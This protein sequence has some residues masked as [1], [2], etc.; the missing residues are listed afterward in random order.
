MNEINSFIFGNFDSAKYDIIMTEPTPVVFAER[1]VESIIVAG[2]SGNIIKDNGRYKNVS[3]P[4]RCALIPRDDLTLREAA[5]G[6]VQ[7]L[8]M[9]TGY[10]QLEDTYDPDHF[11]VA[12]VSAGLNI[13]SIV[14]QAGK[15]TLTFDCK[16]QR[17]LKSGQMPLVF[18]KPSILFN[19]GE[20]AKPLITVYGSGAGTLTVGS[21]TVQIKEMDDIL[22]LDSDLENGYRQIGN[23][24][25]ESM[26]GK[27]YA[28]KF[29]VL[30]AGK[31]AIDWSG[32]VTKVEIIPRWW[33]L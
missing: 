10:Q 23:G 13:E 5:I 2:R 9:A 31:N 29:P 11:R 19:Q 24:A 26:N 14:E 32:G 4:Y 30:M 17:Y 25:P 8:R 28:P 3:I 20:E 27:I 22:I 6:A 7:S 33:T 18:E 1:D 12:R 21:I 16:P 15:F